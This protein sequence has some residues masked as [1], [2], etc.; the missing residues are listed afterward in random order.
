M[1]IRQLERERRMHKNILYRFTF[2]TT[3]KASLKRVPEE[4]NTKD[5]ETV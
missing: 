4:C 1:G 2:S 3:P 5:M